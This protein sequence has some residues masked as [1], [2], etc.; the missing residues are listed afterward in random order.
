MNMVDFFSNEYNEEMW[1]NYTRLFKEANINIK[2]IPQDIVNVVMTI[3][4]DDAGYKWLHTPFEKFNG[5]NALEL[6]ETPKG[7]RALKA[8]II[9]LPN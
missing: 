6:L 4:G 3:L 5:K 1:I 9:R 2:G 7:E 8:F